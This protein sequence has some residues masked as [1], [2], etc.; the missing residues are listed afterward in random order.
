M[1]RKV[2]SGFS[3]EIFL[4]LAGNFYFYPMYELTNAWPFVNF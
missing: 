4:T 1:K 3:V 2:W